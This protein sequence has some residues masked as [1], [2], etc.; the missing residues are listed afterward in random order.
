MRKI[1]LKINP[2]REKFPVLEKKKKHNS[3]PQQLSSVLKP[4]SFESL[5]MAR[6]MRLWEPHEEQNAQP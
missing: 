5:W 2:K 6:H 3:P 1:Q 4:I